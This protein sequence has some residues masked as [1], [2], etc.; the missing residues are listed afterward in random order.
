MTYVVAPSIVCDDVVATVTV[1]AELSIF[2]MT[3]DCPVFPT[4]VGNVTAKDAEVASP[5]IV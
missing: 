1:F 4:A 5:P 2:L 3:N